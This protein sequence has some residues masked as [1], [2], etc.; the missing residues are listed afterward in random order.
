MPPASGD[1][2]QGK[3]ALARGLWFDTAKL[4]T[5]SQATGLDRRFVQDPSLAQFGVDTAYLV[6]RALMPWDRAG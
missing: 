6:P 1:G 4:P 2:A 5:D 3:G